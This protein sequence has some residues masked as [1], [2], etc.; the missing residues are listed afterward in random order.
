MSNICPL[1]IATISLYIGLSIVYKSTDQT[2]QCSC[3]LQM[4]PPTQFQVSSAC[5]NTSSRENPPQVSRVIRSRGFTV[6][7]QHVERDREN[8]YAYPGDSA[9]SR[10]LLTS[11]IDAV[12]PYLPC[13]RRGD[14][15]RGPGSKKAILACLSMRCVPLNRA[16]GQLLCRRLCGNR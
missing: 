2:L 15:I 12:P 8:T 14:L 13:E 16:H 7:V 10:A 6:E 9:K 5:T 4:S 3:P 11:H 1:I